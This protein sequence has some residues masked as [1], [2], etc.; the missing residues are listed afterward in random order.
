ME[1]KTKSHVFYDMSVQRPTVQ[2]RTCEVIVSDAQPDILRI[3]GVTGQLFGTG[4]SLAGNG[5]EFRPVLRAA[6]L[7]LPED[8]DGICSIPVRTELPFRLELG[9]AAGEETLTMPEMARILGVTR[10][11][12]CGSCTPPFL[13]TASRSSLP[14]I[15][16]GH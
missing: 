9:D 2:E 14:A 13:F 7:Y 15:L 8:G 6:V 16:R 1:L 11:R 12:V 10:N 4:P 5:A 3:C